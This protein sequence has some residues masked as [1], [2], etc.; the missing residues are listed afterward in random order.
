M[1]HKSKSGRG[2]GLQCKPS[3]TCAAPVDWLKLVYVQTGCIDSTAISSR[4]PT[5]RSP[6]LQELEWSLNLCPGINYVNNNLLNLSS[7]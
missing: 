6:N 7:F 5:Q 1:K 2:G 4:G 3:C